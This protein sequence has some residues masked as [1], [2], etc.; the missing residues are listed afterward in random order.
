MRGGFLLAGMGQVEGTF[1][2]PDR[3]V[4]EMFW[5]IGEMF[6]RLEPWREVA[7]MLGGLKKKVKKCWIKK[8]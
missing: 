8:H 1:I 2:Q 5:G 3:K 6:G 4:G 7:K